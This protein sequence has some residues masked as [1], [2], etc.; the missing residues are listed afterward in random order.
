MIQM[1]TNHLTRNNPCVGDQYGNMN[2]KLHQSMNTSQNTQAFESK[3][4][5]TLAESLNSMSKEQYHKMAERIFNKWQKGEEEAYHTKMNNLL[6]V[7]QRLYKSAL[8]QPFDTIK[9]SGDK[10]KQTRSLEKENERLRI[11]IQELEM[12]EQKN[13]QTQPR[14]HNFQ[15]KTNNNKFVL[16]S[17]SSHRNSL[18]SDPIHGNVETVGQLK[19]AE[20]KNKKNPKPGVHHKYLKNK[21]PTKKTKKEKPNRKGTKPQTPMNITQDMV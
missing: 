2:S 21:V 13:F 15:S 19:K 1:F 18:L 14:K 12:R 5:E 3:M 11:E 16:D 7:G 8:Q 9:S 10:S 20:R 17:K 6:K 4:I